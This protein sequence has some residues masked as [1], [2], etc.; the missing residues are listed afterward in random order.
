M[1]V[2]SRSLSSPG[3]V[4][5]TARTRDVESLLDHVC[6]REAPSALPFTPRTYESIKDSCLRVEDEIDMTVKS[7]KHRLR[8]PEL[9][10]ISP[11]ATAPALDATA[12]G[13]N[14]SCLSRGTGAPS[15]RRGL[16]RA[17]SAA[18]AADEAKAKRGSVHERLRQKISA[19]REQ[20]VHGVP[21]TVDGHGAVGVDLKALQQNSVA[22]QL[23]RETGA[24]SGPLRGEEVARFCRAREQVAA[25]DLRRTRSAPNFLQQNTDLRPALPQ[26]RRHAMLL[27]CLSR[28]VR[29][30]AA[31][32][33]REEGFE[34]LRQ[35]ADTDYRERYFDAPEVAEPSE[36]F[37]ELGQLAEAGFCSP[38]DSPQ[39][40]T[41][42]SSSSTSCVDGAVAKRSGK[43]AMS[44]RTPVPVVSLSK[45]LPARMLKRIMRVFAHEQLEG[46]F[47]GS[48]WEQW[49]TAFR[50][51]ALMRGLSAWV[52]RW[53]RNRAA[54]LLKTFL[55][56]PQP[57]VL[58][59]KLAMQRFASRLK[60]IQKVW[61]LFTWR[62][63]STVEHVL[64][65]L[66]VQQEREILDLVFNACPLER[67]VCVGLPE[68]L[69]GESQ[70]GC[71]TST[72]SV[73]SSGQAFQKPPKLPRPQA[74]WRPSGRLTAKEAPAKEKAAAER[75]RQTMEMQQ[76]INDAFRRN[77]RQRVRACRFRPAVAAKIIRRELIERLYH[78]ASRP[79]LG[80]CKTGPARC[81]GL[82]AAVRLDAEEVDE[83]ICA[84]HRGQG[85]KPC[86]PNLCASLLPCAEWRVAAAEKF[87]AG[88]PR[89][90]REGTVDRWGEERRN[91]R[92]ATESD[93]NSSSVQ[94]QST[95][96]EEEDAPAV[97]FRSRG[98]T[99]RAGP[100]S[101]SVASTASGCSSS[102]PVKRRPASANASRRAASGAVPADTAAGGSLLR[103]GR[104]PSKG[105]A[106]SK[107]SANEKSEAKATKRLQLEGW[108]ASSDASAAED[109]QSQRPST[110]IQMNVA[111]W[112]SAHALEAP[113]SW[114]SLEQLLVQ[115]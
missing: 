37:E 48:P 21:L 25:Q 88:R 23:Q 90:I 92:V 45:L 26:A 50:L 24:S 7:I 12:T 65:G 1:G 28:C 33:R 49:T 60:K 2:L 110:D 82:P 87:L 104:Q 55:Q 5:E 36:S 10:P 34:A 74:P 13:V 22:L 84:S 69:C 53:R 47:W 94:T 100:R 68:L 115:K 72:V 27:R 111:G 76:M 52:Q 86:D 4:T 57:L 54:E 114:P 113:A 9:F 79:G 15:R 89:S 19:C 32:S 78:H 40:K 43:K 99:R 97:D 11:T 14:I 77:V 70:S 112:P 98:K 67:D 17:N 51:L 30:D 44:K 108:S 83:L 73:G 107:S 59:V 81:F 101:L 6:V 8:T 56:L 103:R 41:D 75:R 64:E 106:G 29:A 20:G 35:R 31:R 71:D 38:E 46:V 18:A 91:S 61:R 66:W 80:G 93:A 85:V 58:Q 102:S 109:F 42:R 16:R 39:A 62:L 96:E 63:A 105:R 95:Q 3:L